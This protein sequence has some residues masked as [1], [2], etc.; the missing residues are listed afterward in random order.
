[1]SHTPAILYLPVELLCKLSS[2]LEGLPPSFLFASQITESPV[3]VTFLG[4][5]QISFSLCLPLRGHLWQAPPWKGYFCHFGCLFVPQE[6]VIFSNFVAND[7][8]LLL[9]CLLLVNTLLF[10]HLSLLKFIFS[11]LVKGIH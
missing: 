4:E 1:M 2:F 10:F 8:L 11:L 3:K 5:G 7:Y 6:L 9:F